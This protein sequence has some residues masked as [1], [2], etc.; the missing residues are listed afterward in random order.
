[1]FC[2]SAG[3]FQFK[4]NGLH[5]GDQVRNTL[6]LLVVWHSAVINSCF[7]KQIHTSHASLSVK[8]DP[9]T[10]SVR[11]H[12]ADGNVE[13]FMIISCLKTAVIYLNK[14]AGFPVVLRKA[15]QP[16]RP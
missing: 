7:Y 14:I 6:W 12:P 3:K 2:L 16:S 1:M 9:V 10:P 8:G 15:A 4:G 13:T 11:G 5:S